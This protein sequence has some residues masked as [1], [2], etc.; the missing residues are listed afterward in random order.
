MLKYKNYSL[1]KPNTEQSSQIERLIDRYDGSV[2]HEVALNK[3]VE[4]HFGTDLYYLVD[5]CININSFAPVH[6]IK[7]K[8]GA[9]R[10]EL[11]P[12]G[13]IPYAGFAG[14]NSPVDLKQL[15]VGL[16]E[17]AKYSGFPYPQDKIHKN[18]GQYAF[19][20]TNMVDLGESEDDIFTAM[21]SSKRR[22]IRKAIKAGIQ[23]K[24]YFDVEGF[25][26]FWPILDALHKKL[27]YSR[28]TYE[29]YKKFIDEF[30]T[31]KKIFTLIAYK[32]DQPVSG[33]LI[34]GNKNYAHFFKGAS[35]F[36]VKPEGQG[37]LIHWEAIKI[38]KESG[39]RYYDLCNLNKE[40]LPEIYR[41]KTGI[42]NNIINYTKYTKNSLGYKIIN[43]F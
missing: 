32:N 30:S 27:G 22:N 17:S 26:V 1:I 19:G 7:G 41:F 11:N 20:E 8:K 2:F 31:K 9:K 6:V 40:K 24:Q 3:I 23:V 13:D 29:Y 18:T 16:F 34:I 15:S 25:N 12:L 21:E 10:Y 5:D 43:H 38:L 33:L 4:S 14:N 28:F 36:N 37:E 42:S 39:V 35:D